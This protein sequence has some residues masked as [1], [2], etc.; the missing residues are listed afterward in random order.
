VQLSVND[1]PMTRIEL[2]GSGFVRGSLP[3]PI[4]LQP[5]DVLKLQTTV[6]A[7]GG[8]AG[9]PLRFEYADAYLSCL[10]GLGKQ[11]PFYLDLEPYTYALPLYPLPYQA[12]A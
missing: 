2:S 3:Q 12:S 10:L 1:R 4:T 7:A 8:S 6:A 5:G 11:S 9:L